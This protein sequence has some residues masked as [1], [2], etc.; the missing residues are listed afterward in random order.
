MFRH[1]FMLYTYKEFSWLE[2]I[3]QMLMTFGKPCNLSI[4]LGPLSVHLKQK[5][6]SNEFVTE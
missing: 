2:I 4:Q 6:S 1:G 3:Y 5:K